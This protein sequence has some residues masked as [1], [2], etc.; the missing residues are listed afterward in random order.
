MG[1]GGGGTGGGG[2]GRGGGGWARILEKAVILKEHHVSD[3]CNT[4]YFTAHFHS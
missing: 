1:Y 4:A 2:G 3:L